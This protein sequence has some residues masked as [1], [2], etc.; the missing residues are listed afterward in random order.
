MTDKSKH[1]VRQVRFRFC[2]LRFLLYSSFDLLRC[3]PVKKLRN[4]YKRASWLVTLETRLAFV[5][6]K[7]NYR[8]RAT[9]MLLLLRPK[10]QKN[11]SLIY[12]V[13]SPVPSHFPD[14][15]L[16]FFAKIGTFFIFKPT[17][18][19]S[20]TQYCVRHFVCKTACRFCAPAIPSQHDEKKE[21]PRILDSASSARVKNLKLAINNVNYKSGGFTKIHGFLLI[22]N[23]NT[24]LEKNC[25]SA[26]ASTLN[27]SLTNKG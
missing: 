12:A 9:N 17:L 8:S 10:E 7:I 25:F 27:M 24:S 5:R 2:L 13:A 21:R 19:K 6:T 18:D 20:F 26:W 22:K 11:R 4:L 23:S 1:K 15:E 14:I 3:I 16:L